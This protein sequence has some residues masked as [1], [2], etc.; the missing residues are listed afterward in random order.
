M[1]KSPEGTPGL[2][3]GS[4]NGEQCHRAVSLLD[5]YPTLGTLCGLPERHDLDGHTLIPLLRDPKAEREYPAITSYD[6][7]EF[8]VSTEE[9]RYIQYIDGSE[10]LYDHIKDEEEWFNLANDPKYDHVKEQLIKHIPS[11][12]APLKVTSVKLK[13]HHQPPFRSRDEYQE[14]LNHGKDTKY[15]IEKY[16]KIDY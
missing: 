15:I 7:S 1:I 5:I 2:P 16:W 9:W 6:F 4:K 12:P 13:P 11:S 14:W 10:E 8:A 3:E